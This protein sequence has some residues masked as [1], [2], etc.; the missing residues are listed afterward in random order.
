LKEKRVKDIKSQ[1]LKKYTNNELVIL[2]H[3]SEQAF[4]LKFYENH[5]LKRLTRLFSK[6]SW[7]KLPEIDPANIDF[8]TIQNL[9]DNNI[10]N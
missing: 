2:A 9:D 8:H 4:N 6:V 7:L 3:Q 10:F 1:S 5:P